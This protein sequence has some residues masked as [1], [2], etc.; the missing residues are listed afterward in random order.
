M[1]ELFIKEWILNTD[2]NKKSHTI[3]KHSDSYPFD[4]PRQA[5]G[6]CSG[7]TLMN[8]NKGDG[9]QDTVFLT[10]TFKNVVPALDLLSKILILTCRNKR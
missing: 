8:Y 3:T 4:T 9:D 6:P 10:L 5:Q 2:R 7:S 1:S